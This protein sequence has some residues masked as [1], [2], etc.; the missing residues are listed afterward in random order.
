MEGNDNIRLPTTL[1]QLAGEY[2]LQQLKLH[3]P[4][5]EMCKMNLTRRTLCA[6]LTTV[7][8]LNIS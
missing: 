6:G 7:T 4:H 8:Q 5:L 1:P 3:L 2:E